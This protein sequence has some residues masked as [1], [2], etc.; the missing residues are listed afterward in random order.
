MGPSWSQD[1]K[2]IYGNTPTGGKIIR[3]RIADGQVE[4]LFDG[5]QPV[6]TVDGKRLLYAKTDGSGIYWRSLEGNP[7]SNPEERI[8]DDYTRAPG[9]GFVP[10]HNGFFYVGYSS[11]GKPRSFKFYDTVRRRATEISPYLGSAMAVSPDQRQLL[12]VVKNSS[13]DLVLTEFR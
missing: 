7:A 8:V 2:Y 4:P 12:C 6:E 5:D 11:E 3:I 10:V 9:A 1:G 13:F